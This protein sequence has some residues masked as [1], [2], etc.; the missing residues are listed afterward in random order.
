MQ[1]LFDH[2]RPWNSVSLANSVLIK[3]ICR[4]IDSQVISRV[5]I[6]YKSI[7]LI[8]LQDP[9]G[10]RQANKHPNSP[11]NLPY[12]T[13]GLIMLNDF[14]SITEFARTRKFIF[15]IQSIYSLFLVGSYNCHHKVGSYCWAAWAPKGFCNGQRILIIGVTDFTN[16]KAFR[17]REAR[18]TYCKS[19]LEGSKCPNS[20]IRVKWAFVLPQFTSC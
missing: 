17:L 4:R 3:Q 6:Q 15:K 5:R 16:L 10:T 2:V 7:L 20:S 18:D 11:Q 1:H 14:I 19:L 13:N 8:R 12:V 9:R